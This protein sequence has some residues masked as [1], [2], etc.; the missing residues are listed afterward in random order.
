VGDSVNT[1][2]RLETLTKDFDAQ[3]VF[4]EAVA[5]RAGL[6]FEGMPRHEIEIRG[7][8]ERLKVLPLASALDLPPAETRP[9]ARHRAVT[10]IN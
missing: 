1:A 8:V 3:L 4:S 6:S 9:P 2:S 5:E 10:P 7:R